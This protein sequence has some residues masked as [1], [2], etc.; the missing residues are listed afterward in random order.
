MQS[1]IFKRLFDVYHEGFP[2]DSEA[3]FA[4]FMQTVV[5]YETIEGE[6]E[7]VSIGFLIEKNAL[8]MGKQTQVGY[9]SGLCTRKEHRG[10]GFISRLIPRLLEKAWDRRYPLVFLSPFADDFYRRY[11]FQDLIRADERII[12]PQ[13]TGGVTVETTFSPAAEVLKSIYAD[14]VRNCKNRLLFGEKEIAEKLHEFACDG[15]PISIV[16]VGSLPKAF[17]FLAGKTIEYWCGD[18]S[19]LQKAFAHTGA[20]CY[21]FQDA[22]HKAF[23]QMRVCNV[24]EF[25]RLFGYIKESGVSQIKDAMIRQNNITLKMREKDANVRDVCFFT[26]KAIKAMTETGKFFNDKY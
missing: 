11:G 2:E 7:I 26:Q 20:N 24:N 13:D 6:D 18:F 1:A 25:E 19:A 12:A 8:I 9:L 3:F 23:V 17:C 16:R 21:C 14:S 10:K 4:H 5:A 22:G 15:I